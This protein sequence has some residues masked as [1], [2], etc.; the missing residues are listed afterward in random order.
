MPLLPTTKTL[1]LRSLSI[2]GVLLGL[3][4]GLL[5]CL[6]MVLHVV[7]FWALAGMS[8]DKP[9]PPKGEAVRVLCMGDSMTAFGG[10]DAYPW[11]LEALLEERVPSRD[12]HV[13]VAAK[14]GIDTSTLLGIAD[15]ALE[16]SE[17]D[18]VTVMIG[19]NDDED[20]FV[21]MNRTSRTGGELGL[22]GQT[23]LYRFWVLAQQDR[24]AREDVRRQRAKREERERR[25]LDEFGR[26]GDLKAGV[27]L[28]RHY[29]PA[30]E[31]DRAAT[32]L[33]DLPRRDTSPDATLLLAELTDDPAEACALYQDALERFP[34]QHETYRGPLLLA[35]MVRH[36]AASER[37]CPFDEQELLAQ[38]IRHLPDALSHN[39]QGRFYLDR[40]LEEAEE[41]AFLRSIDTDPGF[42][43]PLAL[44]ELYTAQGRH[45][46]AEAMLER[47][48]RHH[49]GVD[50]QLAL[51]RLMEAQGRSEDAE[52][53]YKAAIELGKGP[54]RRPTK[55]IFE[56]RE[57]DPNQAVL[58]LSRLY[59]RE[60]KLADAEAVLDELTFSKRG[61]QSYRQLTER[62]L[63]QTGKL[64]VIQYPN[65][66][67]DPLLAMLP[68]RHGLVSVDNREVFERAVANH[69]WYEIFEDRSGG[70]FG[71]LTPEGHRLVA[72][73][74]ADMVIAR[75]FR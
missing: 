34:R 30:G 36:V 31:R 5:V 46:E 18:I 41:A 58:E 68:E 51:A 62:I 71:H 11:Q 56:H 50:A 21:E 32:V 54:M 25:L 13:S 70:D 38:Q 67:V 10:D 33:R 47:S 57:S 22:L 59:R 61:M 20:W 63:D 74:T 4:L 42:Y 15:D 17:P 8:N 6:E 49:T 28:A 55:E 44:G 73:A 64:V 2:L 26:R 69:G 12:F 14:P 60:G 48:L 45:A 23:K 75:W 72:E 27:T 65:R 39:E 1:L 43:A 9:L 35:R 29:H 16:R 40:G 52:A 24:L 7:G 19:V 53:T 37:A 66:S 3:T